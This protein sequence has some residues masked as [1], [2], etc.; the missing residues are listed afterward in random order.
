MKNLNRRMNC[1]S[2]LW[3]SI[4]FVRKAWKLTKCVSIENPTPI[5]DV[6]I[7]ASH[8]GTAL[9]GSFPNCLRD[10]HTPTIP[11]LSC[12]L[13]GPQPKIVPKRLLDLVQKDV[14]ENFPQLQGHVFAYRNSRHCFPWIVTYPGTLCGQGFATGKSLSRLV[15]RR[16]GFDGGW[17]GQCGHGGGLA[18]SHCCHG[19]FIH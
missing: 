2:S 12:L 6:T 9:D 1:Y 10:A 5:T 16:F 8:S 11:S 18:Y 4:L 3:L 15:C 14:L 19:I 17:F 13:P 7:R